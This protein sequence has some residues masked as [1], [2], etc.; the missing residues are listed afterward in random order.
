MAE[1]RNWIP[2]FQALALVKELIGE[3]RDGKA[4]DVLVSWAAAGDV[5]ARCRLCRRWRDTDRDA[6]EDER[7]ALVGPMFWHSFGDL[8]EA[9]QSNWR[10]GEFRIA[11][12]RD[13]TYHRT[14]L[15]GVEFD[16]DQIRSLAPPRESHRSERP[17]EQEEEGSEHKRS[18]P[19]LP[20]G[21]LEE[22]HRLF[23]AAYPE[24]TVTLAQ[25]SVEGMFP[26]HHVARSRTRDL[27]PNAQ[28][29]RPRKNKE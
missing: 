11:A 7:N 24:G 29:G 8:E 19:R 16:A 10:A 14:R 26:N 5:A 3:N 1:E 28:R 25:K 17:V 6:V 13:Y 4:A 15:T 23:K 20:Q 22:W 9:D 21:F 27:F 18:L 12:Y 2:A